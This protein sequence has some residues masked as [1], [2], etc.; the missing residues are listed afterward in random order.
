MNKLYLLLSAVL[1]Q[2]NAAAQHSTETFKQI[3]KIEG[4]WSMQK[5]NAAIFEN[6][7][8]VSDNEYT[9]KSW[10]IK[11]GDSALSETLILSFKN[12][13]IKYTST[14]AGQNDGKAVS[15]TLTKAENNTYIFENA[16]HDFPKRIIY[17]FISDDELTAFIDDG[18]PGTTKKSV[19]NYRR[20]KE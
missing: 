13:V 20:Q 4:A 7:K 3:G 5:G 19:F 15:F 1:W 18:V 8:K 16:Q 10:I 2:L 11:N 9:G 14:V 12:G 17:Q 6:W